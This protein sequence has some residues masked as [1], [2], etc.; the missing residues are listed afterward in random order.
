M[1]MRNED[2]SS[3]TVLTMQRSTQIWVSMGFTLEGIP[4]SCVHRK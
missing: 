4:W 1:L 3:K 2:M